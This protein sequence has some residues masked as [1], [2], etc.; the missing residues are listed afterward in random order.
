LVSSCSLFTICKK[1]HQVATIDELLEIQAIRKFS[2]ELGNLE[3]IKGLT[4][5]IQEKIILLDRQA[6]VI[7]D[8][9]LEAIPILSQKNGYSG[10]IR[11]PNVRFDI[12]VKLSETYYNIGKD[13]IQF[14]FAANKGT[15]FGILKKV[16]SGGEMSQLCSL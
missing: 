1:K 5:A 8:R 13:E 15:D 12:Q 4:L 9:R 6:S 11:M 2:F 10:Y 14:L 3:E 16:A 7:H